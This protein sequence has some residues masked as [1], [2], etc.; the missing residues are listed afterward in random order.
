MLIQSL[1]VC[2]TKRV[3]VL[4]RMDGL[5]IYDIYFCPIWFNLSPEDY[6]WTCNSYFFI[7]IILIF[8]RWC[9]STPASH[10]SVYLIYLS[11]LIFPVRPVISRAYLSFLS[12]CLSFPYLITFISCLSSR[13][14][15]PHSL[16]LFISFGYSLTRYSLLFPNVYVEIY[17]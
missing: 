1:I 6:W 2:D 9:Q 7:R 14:L 4:K 5:I 13:S 15:C 3:I 11:G 17:P 8:Y 16:S 10:Y 12:S